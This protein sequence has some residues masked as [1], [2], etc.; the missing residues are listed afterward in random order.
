MFDILLP[1]ILMEKI[2]TI[3]NHKLHVGEQST[4]GHQPPLLILPCPL[5]QLL[6]LMASLK[7]TK[8]DGPK[9]GVE[10]QHGQHE[11]MD[12]GTRTTAGDQIPEHFFAQGNE[13]I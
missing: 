5:G 3:L 4:S 8:A 10:C 13:W 1:L 11:Q 9:H 2:C 6:P 12:E 7:G